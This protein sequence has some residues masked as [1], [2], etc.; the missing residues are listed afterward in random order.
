M[1]TEILKTK[2][3]TKPCPAVFLTAL[4]VTVPPL[5]ANQMYFN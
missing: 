3:H 1:E 2:V 4:F 5:Q